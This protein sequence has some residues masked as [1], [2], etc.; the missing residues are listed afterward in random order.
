MLSCCTVPI[1][2][3]GWVSEFTILDQIGGLP[4]AVYRRALLERGAA[5]KK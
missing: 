1:V 2:E 5:L 3:R 4:N